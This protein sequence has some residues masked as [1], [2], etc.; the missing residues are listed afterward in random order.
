M[1]IP[2]WGAMPI[3]RLIS[4]SFSVAVGSQIVHRQDA[5]GSALVGD[6]NADEGTAS[7]FFR[8]IQTFRR[9]VLFDLADIVDQKRDLFP[10]GDDEGPP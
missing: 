7:H 2:I 10:E 3:S 8:E 5:F 9:E 4:V 1:L 6:G